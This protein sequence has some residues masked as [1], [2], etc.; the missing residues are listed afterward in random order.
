MTYW[1]KMIDSI[2]IFRFELYNTY[3][4]KLKMSQATKRLMRDFQKIQA[5]DDPDIIATP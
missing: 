4:K 3:N 1:L 5:E 2:S